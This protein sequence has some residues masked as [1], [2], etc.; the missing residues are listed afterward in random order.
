[1]SE[2]IGSPIAVPWSKKDYEVYIQI[3][4]KEIEDLK[5]ELHENNSAKVF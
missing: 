1:M 3:L 4:L 5:K 2:V